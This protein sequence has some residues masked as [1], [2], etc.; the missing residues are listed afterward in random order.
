MKKKTERTNTSRKG[1][2]GG[3]FSII[4]A[5]LITPISRLAYFIKD[6]LSFKS[7]FIDRILNKPNVLLYL[8]LIL[9]FVCFFAVD[10]KVISFTDTEAVVLSNQKV[11]AEFNEEA[12]VV[13]GVPESADIILMGRKSD[14]YLAQQLGEHK[15]TLDLTNYGV[16]THKVKLEYN[17]PINTLSY[18][19]DPGSLTVVVYPK[20]SEVRTL[21][22]DPI[23]TDK[24][25]D[26]LVVSNIILDR[27]DIIIKSYQE[28][29]GTVA[30]VKA[31]VDVSSIN[32]TESGTYTIENVKLV[33][34]D[35][36]GKEIKDIEIVPST[37]TA[38]VTITSP[39]KTVPLKITTVG[40]VRTGSAISNITSSVSSVTVYADDSILNEL[41]FIEVEIEVEGLSENKTFQKYINKPNGARSISETSVTITVTMEEA[42]DK[43]F[44]N[45]SIETEG[46][47]KDKFI[48][49]ASSQED[50]LV[51][52]NVKGV[53]S[54]LDSL[55]PT[56]IHAY[57]DLSDIVEPG[58]Y[59]VPVYVRGTDTRLIYNSRTKNVKIIILNKP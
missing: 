18:K 19:L 1:L 45:I 8:A 16:G 39:S 54:L 15:I 37:V 44:E 10:R 53:K 7:G 11:S 34:Y 42:T 57:V 48:V 59:T 52:V 55:D 35:E 40:N 25:A 4:D 23:N 21:T 2:I 14:L 56:N 13:E 20:V 58:A 28:K 47:D 41:N 17:N 43:D 12:Y 24:L 9:A 29:L 5:I 30:N 49:Q 50:A 3:L 22:V 6:K 26:T 33:A 51:T 38:T 36:S 46:L 32:A 27:D 31:L